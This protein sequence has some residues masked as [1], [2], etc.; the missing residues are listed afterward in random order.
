VRLLLSLACS[1]NWFLFQLDVDNA[2]LHGDLQEEVYMK[3]PPRHILPQH[4]LVC[5][6]QKSLYGLKQANRQW[7]SKLIDALLHIGFNQSFVD[8]SLFVKKT[9]TSFTTLLVYVDDIVLAGTD[10][11]VTED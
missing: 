9:S 8:H 3:P 7:N 10:L 4:N 1:H 2:F 11:S 5:K 6:L